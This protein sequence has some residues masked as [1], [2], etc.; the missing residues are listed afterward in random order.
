MVAPTGFDYIADF[1]P[2]KTELKTALEFYDEYLEYKDDRKPAEEYELV[3]NWQM[4]FNYHSILNWL[5]RMGIDKSNLPFY[6]LYRKAVDGLFDGFYR[7]F[8]SFECKMNF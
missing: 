4:T 8:K 6:F 2:S 7:K 1:N 5:M 3:Q